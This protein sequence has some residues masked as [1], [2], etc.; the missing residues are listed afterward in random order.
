MYVSTTDSYF[1]I[2]CLDSSA[3]KYLRQLTDNTNTSTSTGIHS[4]LIKLILIMVVFISVQCIQYFSMFRKFQD[5]ANS[6]MVTVVQRV[7]LEKFTL[8]PIWKKCINMV[9]KT[10]RDV[11]SL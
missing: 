9:N 6:I 4:I 1:I 3:S 7:D 11:S 5:E 8:F 2:K 10:T